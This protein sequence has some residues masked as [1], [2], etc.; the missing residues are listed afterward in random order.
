MKRFSD[1]QIFRLSKLQKS[2]FNKEHEW[3]ELTQ[4]FVRFA[5]FVFK[6]LFLCEKFQFSTCPN[7]HLFL[8]H[9]TAGCDFAVGGLDAEHVGA[10]WIVGHGY[11]HLARNCIL[12]SNL[13]SECVVHRYV[14]KVFALHQNL[15]GSRIGIHLHFDSRRLRN[16]NSLFAFQIHAPP[17]KPAIVR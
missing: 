10:F 1:F 2:I 17:K 13:L 3:H 11:H 14:G 15:I 6:R 4:I 8:Y 16:T 9:Q 5:L 12:R 7:S